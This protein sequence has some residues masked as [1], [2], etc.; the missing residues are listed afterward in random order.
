MLSYER[1]CKTNLSDFTT[2]IVHDK[3]S[4]VSF[5]KFVLQNFKMTFFMPLHQK[6]SKWWKDL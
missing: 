5:G 6:V 3:D 4:H 1:I 2:K